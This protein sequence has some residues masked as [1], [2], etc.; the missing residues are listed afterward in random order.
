[1]QIKLV[2]SNVGKLLIIIGISMLIPFFTALLYHEDCSW[3]F[4]SIAGLSILLGAMMAKGFHDQQQQRMLVRDGYG[5]VILGWLLATLLGMLPYLMT[6][7][8]STVADA[9]FETMSGFTTVGA[10]VLDDIE[11]CDY[12][13]LMWRS[14][15]HWMGGMGILVLFV[16]IL[17][18]T[19][20]GAMQ[21]FKA[22]ASGPVK[23]KLMPK[24]ADTARVLWVIYI[25][26]TVILTVLYL[27][28]GMNLFDAINHSFSTIATGGFSTKNASLGSYQSVW[29]DYIAVLGMFLAGINYSLY[30]YAFRT[31]SLA[32]FKRSL[33]FKAY[34]GVIMVATAIV[35]LDVLAFYDYHFLEAFRYSIFQVVSIIT[36]TGFATCDFE[37]WPLMAQMVLIILC[38]TGACAGST[39]GGIKIDRHI[40]LF[41][42]MRYEVKKFL[43][44][45]MVSHL[46]LNGKPLDEDVVL[47]VTTFFY[48][49]MA[50]IAVSSYLICCTGVDLKDAVTG[51]LSCLGGIGPAIGVWGPSESY[52]SA[53][54]FAKWLMSFLM[55]LGRLEIYTMLVFI[56]PLFKLG[57]KWRN[58]R[59]EFSVEG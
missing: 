42:K 39:S 28:A 21:I 7:T 15:T 36:T 14:V 37:Q 20:T 4:A 25:I 13:V 5:I 11:G 23:D 53:P 32:G 47:S 40:I 34:L 35:W 26:N 3:V 31:R 30:F 22:E 19:G 52:S 24:I 18:H 41:Q 54:A 2:L 43:H 29:V 1:M 49:Y 45:R 59:D 33:E 44:P 50:F 38:L 55:L 46:R 56:K 12:A 6:G 17:S 48:I 27:L 51:S 10:S 8:F 16:A 58:R 57:K 9:F